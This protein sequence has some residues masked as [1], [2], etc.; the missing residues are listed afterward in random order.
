MI[1][2]A[3]EAEF[4]ARIFQFPTSAIKLNG[5]KINYYDFLNHEQ[6]EDCNEALKRIDMKEI[7]GFINQ[8]S[9]ISDLQKEFYKQYINAR[10]G[11]AIR[12]AYELAIRS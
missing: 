12:Q 9:G 1:Q 11:L 8:L 6:D 4:H 5:R 2:T 7:E 3:I 10:Y